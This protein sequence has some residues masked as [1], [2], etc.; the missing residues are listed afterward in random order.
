MSSKMSSKNILTGVVVALAVI[1]AVVAI[2]VKSNVFQKKEETTTEVETVVESE[3][4]VVSQTN[5]DGEVEYLTMVSTYTR[6]KY[7]ALYTYPTSETSS[8][9]E[10][11]ET[12]ESTTEIQY[13]E[14][15]SWVYVT[16]EEG[17]RQFLDDG[18]PITETVVYTVDANSLTTT[19]PVPQ[20]SYVQVTKENGE[21]DGDKTEVVTVTTQPTTTETK[22]NIWEST[23]T[24]TKKD[25]KIDINTP[26]RDDVLADKIVE[27]I[28]ADR[29]EQGLDPLEHETKLKASARTNSMALAMPELYGD[30]KAS[31]DYTVQTS[32]GG[33]S[34]Y[35]M[36]TDATK[37]KAQ[38]ADVTK[39]GVGV[40][41]YNGKYYT[42]V[43]Y[44]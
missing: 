44:G 30:G 3:I 18:T 24:T 8:T 40:V 21:P 7:S 14:Q 2:L 26:Q 29:A 28:N 41:V 9:T 13:V 33:E 4:V 38:S 36:V 22:K 12:S 39:I 15:V 42:T 20:T 27:Q 17:R 11:T 31:A 35:M 23:E 19:E 37:S 43:I 5:E 1:L 32:F 34:L 6:P 10:S 25:I 16:D